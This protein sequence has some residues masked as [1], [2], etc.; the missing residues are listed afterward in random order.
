MREVIKKMMMLRTRFKRNFTESSKRKRRRSWLKLMKMTLITKTM[1][2]SNSSKMKSL[3]FQ[4]K[5]KLLFH[6][7]KNS[8]NK[9]KLRTKF[10]QRKIQ[11][12]KRL[13]FHGVTEKMINFITKNQY[14][15]RNPL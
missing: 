2:K 15:F 13:K 4:F 9:K 14:I 3:S 12:K 6:Q 7:T 10:N 11:M 8:H 1:R 5:P